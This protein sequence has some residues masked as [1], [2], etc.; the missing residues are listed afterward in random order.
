MIW[1][2]NVNNVTPFSSVSILN[3]ELANTAW[4]DSFGLPEEIKFCKLFVDFK[5]IQQL[6]IFS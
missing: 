6:N 2:N 3:F 5:I 1:I 4:A